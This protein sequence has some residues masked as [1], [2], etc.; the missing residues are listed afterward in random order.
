MAEVQPPADELFGV[1]W[2]ELRAQS[3][4]MV[5]IVKSDFPCTSAYAL[6]IGTLN[7]GE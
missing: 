7:L 5:G 1:L 6:F 2:F 4:F 3:K